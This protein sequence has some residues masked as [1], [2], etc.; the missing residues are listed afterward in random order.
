MCT[1]HMCVCIPYVPKTLSLVS[2]ERVN[3]TLSFTPQICIHGFYLFSLEL[4]VFLR[5]NWVILHGNEYKL[6]AGIIVG[7]VHDLP[8]VGKIK[9]LLVIN[10]TDLA[11]VVIQYSTYYEKH[12]RAYILDQV[13]DDNKI[14]LHSNLFC[15]SPIHVCKSQTLSHRSFVLLPYFMCTM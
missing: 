11:F 8:I 12:F 4:Y 6:N 9:Q 7:F 14:V 15:N 3:G 10:E 13:T 5:T 1:L 2:Q